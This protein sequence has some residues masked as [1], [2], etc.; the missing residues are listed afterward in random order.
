VKKKYKKPKF[1][2]PDRITV[3]GEDEAYEYWERNRA[4]WEN[5][6]GAID[7]VKAILR[8]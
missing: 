3:G 4:I 1:M 5:V 2:H 8:R 7:W 6:P